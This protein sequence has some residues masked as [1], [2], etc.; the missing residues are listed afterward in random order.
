MKIFALVI[1]IASVSSASQ[2]E[3]TILVRGIVRD[4]Q[5]PA[6][7]EMQFRDETGK[8]V[9]AKS[10]QDGIY[11][12]ILAPGHTYTVTILNDNLERYTFTYITP[13]TNKYTELTQDFSLGQTAV[14][15]NDRQP[16]QTV[17]QP[18]KKSKSKKLKRKQ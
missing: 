17:T 10:G 4:A 9:R 15:G 7:V 11:Q 6:R 2:L 18:V 1:A 13:P 16:Q 5:G 12:T 3:P 14:A 8:S